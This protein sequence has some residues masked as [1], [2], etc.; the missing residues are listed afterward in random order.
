MQQEKR[1]HEFKNRRPICP[2]CKQRSSGMARDIC[3]FCEISKSPCNSCGRLKT[4]MSSGLCL[5]C[6][7]D[8]VAN[9]QMQYE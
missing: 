1:H 8:H 3:V 2:T 5:D 4:L 6:Q 9:N 7:L